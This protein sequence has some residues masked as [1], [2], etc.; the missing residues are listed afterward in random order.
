M[1]P[2]LLFDNRHQHNSHHPEARLADKL[3]KPEAEVVDQRFHEMHAPPVAA[4]FLD[5]LHPG[6]LTQ[7]GVAGFLQVH[8]GI[9]V[10]FDLVFGME[11]QLFVEFL[12][13]LLFAVEARE[14]TVY[15]ANACLSAPP[16]RAAHPRVLVAAGRF[17]FNQAP[18]GCELPPHVWADFEKA[19]QRVQGTLLQH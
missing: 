11:A 7:R 16:P 2:Q 15:V 13:G 8:A 5:L 18:D 4:L 12:L 17:A 19:V 9:D 10:L 14:G 1:V 6:K 3:P